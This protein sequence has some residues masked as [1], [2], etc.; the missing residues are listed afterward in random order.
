MAQ[1]PEGKVKDKVK[2]LFKKYEKQ[3]L[4][5][6]YFMPP[7]GP[8]GR[9]GV[10]D[11]IACVEGKF[12]GIECKAGKN[13]PTALQQMELDAIGQ[14][15]GISMIV[16]DSDGGMDE[17]KYQLDNVMLEVTVLEFASNVSR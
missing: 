4:Y 10:P 7:G 9:A 12:F 11:I 8:Y 6:W 16:N 14:C 2:R 3:G 13:K 15:K 5:I 1:T 17:L